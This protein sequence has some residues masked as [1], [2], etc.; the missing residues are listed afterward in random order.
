MFDISAIILVSDDAD[1]IFIK[2][3]S[4]HS[5]KL[6]YQQMLI[7]AVAVCACSLFMRTTGKQHKCCC[8]IK[9]CKL[10]ALACKTFKS[11]RIHFIHLFTLVRI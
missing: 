9:L 2:S 10:T 5:A 8:V 7:L 11:T 3:V 4:V 1:V 6:Q